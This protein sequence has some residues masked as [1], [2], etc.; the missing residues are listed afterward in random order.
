MFDTSFDKKTYSKAILTGKIAISFIITI[1]FMFFVGNKVLADITIFDDNFDNYNE[2]YLNEQGNWYVPFPYDNEVRVWNY[3]V[4]SSPHSIIFQDVYS[5]AVSKTGNISTIGNIKFAV[6]LTEPEQDFQTYG[7]FD[8]RSGEGTGNL[9]IS[10]IQID[11]TKPIGTIYFQDYINLCFASYNK[12]HIIEIDWDSTTDKTRAKC[13]G[14]DFSDWVNSYDIE[15]NDFAYA[16][17]I[18]I[19]IGN[20]GNGFN[21]YIDDIGGSL[22]YEM[23][24]EESCEGLGTVE[25]WLCEIKNLLKGIFLPSSEKTTELKNNMEQIKIKFPFNYLNL[26]NS[27]F[28]DVK[29]G[30]NSTSSIPFKIL[31]QAGA[32][33]LS[34]WERETIVGGISQ[35]FSH[36]IYNFLTIFILFIFTFWIINFIKRI[37]K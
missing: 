19:S 28:T 12:W 21:F 4:F 15:F 2:G 8:V 35:K 37:F 18:R 11:G 26:L 27:F 25:K 23:P 36:I 13:D 10:R 16:Q 32:V 3:P 6:Y 34:F 24:V 31:G 29:N 14:N 9:T 7:Q 17:N 33:D 30:V 5:T 1:F 22:F 20:F